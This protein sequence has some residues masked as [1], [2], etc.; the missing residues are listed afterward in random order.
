MERFVPRPTAKDG[1]THDPRFPIA[2]RVGL[3]IRRWCLTTIWEEELKK[4]RKLL[5]IFSKFR[6]SSLEYQQG[7]VGFLEETSCGQDTEEALGFYSFTL[8]GRL[9]RWVLFLN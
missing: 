8:N 5:I 4:K 1:S 2:D 7:W 9:F 3:C 6:T